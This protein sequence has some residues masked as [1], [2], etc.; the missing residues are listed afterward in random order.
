MCR[1]AIAQ[2]DDIIFDAE[3]LLQPRSGGSA[4]DADSLEDSVECLSDEIGIV[5]QLF[6]RSE[7][8]RSKIRPQHMKEIYAQVCPPSQPSR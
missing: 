2:I 6:S 7:S 8:F 3:Q 5:R 4:D 1:E